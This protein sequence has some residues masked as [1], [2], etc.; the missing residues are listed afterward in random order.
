MVF[1][2]WNDYGPWPIAAV[3]ESYISKFARIST[4]IFVRLITRVDS[5]AKTLV[6]IAKRYIWNGK[7]AAFPGCLNPDCRTWF[8][9][10][11]TV[12]MCHNQT[13]L[14]FESRSYC[15]SRFHRRKS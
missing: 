6:E 13:V 10:L 9:P 14:E 15:M 4:V 1:I 12:Q 8:V 11:A 5:D 3:D 7:C 2:E